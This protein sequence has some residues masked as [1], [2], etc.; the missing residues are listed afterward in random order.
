MIPGRRTS[1]IPSFGCLPGSHDPYSPTRGTWV[2]TVGPDSLRWW[3]REG[4]TRTS[5]CDLAGEEASEKSRDDRTRS[6][7]SLFVVLSFPEPF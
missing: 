5:T 1:V 6:W 7:V 4:A 2:D 3:T